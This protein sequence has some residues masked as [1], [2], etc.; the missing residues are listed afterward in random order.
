[1]RKKCFQ[2]ISK[3]SKNE[4]NTDPKSWISNQFRRILNPI[5]ME[6]TTDDKCPSELRLYK[7]ARDQRKRCKESAYL[8]LSQQNKNTF[9]GAITHTFVQIL[10]RQFHIRYIIISSSDYETEETHQC[11]A[12]F[13]NTSNGRQKFLNQLQHIFMKICILTLLFWESHETK[14]TSENVTAIE[15]TM[16]LH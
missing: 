11:L 8:R 14:N 1:M 12:I 4:R 7:W 10:K 16:K 15:N 9:N 2:M 5:W 13:Q 3:S 6:C